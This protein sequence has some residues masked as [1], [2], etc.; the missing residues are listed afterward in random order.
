MRGPSNSYYRSRGIGSH[1]IAVELVRSTSRRRTMLEI[2]Q[3]REITGLER[4]A[5]HHRQE[6]WLKAAFNKFAQG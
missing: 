6:L 4:V 1:R 5:S 2:D 3:N